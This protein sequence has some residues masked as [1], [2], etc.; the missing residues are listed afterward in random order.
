MS[1]GVC[2]GTGAEVLAE[3][4]LKDEQTAPWDFEQ[5][6]RPILKAKL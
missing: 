3:L 2:K 1:G 4:G 5:R 6:E